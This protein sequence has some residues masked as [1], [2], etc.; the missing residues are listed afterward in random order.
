MNKIFLSIGVLLYASMACFSQDKGY[1]A[2]SGG[3]SMPVGRFGQQSFADNDAGWARLG[4]VYE[5]SLGYKLNKNFGIAGLIRGQRHGIDT[6]KLAIAYSA[7]S[8]AT[9][10][11]EPARWRVGTLMGGSYGSFPVSKRLSVESRL[12]FGVMLAKAPELNVTYTYGGFGA[13]DVYQEDA[14]SIA[15]AYLMGVGFKY[16]ISK[17]I[18]LLL[19]GDYFGGIATFENVQVMMPDFMIT[20]TTRFSQSF[21]T[22][23]IG[24]GIGFRL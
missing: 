8:M 12:M 1:I 18:C 9:A 5:I 22:V 19:N 14:S 24:A 6:D 3:A 21:G 17:G 13:L 7:A 23:N 15:L 20:E 16:D 10:S 2:I 4:A 11:V